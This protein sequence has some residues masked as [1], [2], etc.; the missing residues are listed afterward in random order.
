MVSAVTSWAIWIMTLWNGFANNVLLSVPL[1]LIVFSI[2]L[3]MFDKIK[4]L[5]K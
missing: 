5:I 2:I 3:I 1:L 4:A